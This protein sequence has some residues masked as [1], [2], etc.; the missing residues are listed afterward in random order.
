MDGRRNARDAV[1]ASALAQMGVCER[2]VVF[3]HREGSRMTAA[4]KAALQRGLS[5]HRRFA[6]EE[7]PQE[8]RGGRCFIAMHVL[9]DG[10]ETKTLRD[11]RDWLLRPTRTGRCLILG[12]YRVAPSICR[13]MKRWPALEVAAKA[14][15]RPMVWLAALLIGAQERKH[16]N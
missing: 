14:L 4:K 11:F 16:G 15:L 1:S 12:Y 2:L 10:P 7:S 3:E 13:I 6:S 5:A 9:G 8:G